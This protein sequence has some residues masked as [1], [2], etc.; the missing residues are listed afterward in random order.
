[1]NAADTQS[2]TGI[3]AE[4]QPWRTP[5][6]KEGWRVVGVGKRHPR[7][8]EFEIAEVLRRY[9]PLGLAD[10]T[11]HGDWYAPHARDLVGQLRAHSQPSASPQ[12]VA[13]LLDSTLG[14]VSGEVANASASAPLLMA[15]EIWAAW[16]RYPNP[17][18]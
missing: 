10:G 7:R 5:E 13:R 18:V 8:L 14:Q 12:D 4:P 2:T 9:D 16:Q 17:G 1:M 11:R 3:T 6:D 15:E